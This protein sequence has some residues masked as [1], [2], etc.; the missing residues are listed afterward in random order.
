MGQIIIMRVC[1]SIHNNCV[2]MRAEDRNQTSSKSAS[3]S[4]AN[5]NSR[6][7]S[8]VTTKQPNT[9]DA[10]RGGPSPV[11]RELQNTSQEAGT[12]QRVME[13]QKFP[14]G[15]KYLD[16]RGINQ[17]SSRAQSSYLAHAAL[18]RRTPPMQYPAQQF[19]SVQQLGLVH[20]KEIHSHDN[21]DHLLPRL[22]HSDENINSNQQ[23]YATIPALC[24][25]T[26]QELIC[27]PKA[28]GE[29]INLTKVIPNSFDLGILLLKDNDG[30][31]M[32]TIE[33]RHA[34]HK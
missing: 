13:Q 10:E 14:S 4:T 12:S 21:Y 8:S 5:S 24:K 30:H 20:P 17:Q 25:P 6:N 16:G 32:D 26:L 23:T 28:D 33:W 29:K 18:N 34:M 1:I 9:I 22:P 11:F 27:F 19:A 3:Q 31:I 7:H 2:D 15:S